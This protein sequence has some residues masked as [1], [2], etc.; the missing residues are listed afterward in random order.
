MIARRVNLLTRGDWGGL[1]SLLERDCHLANDEKE[2][3]R[4]G[5][6]RVREEVQLERNRKNALLLLSQG[7]ISKA[8]RTINS[9]GI[10]SMDDPHILQQMEQK[11]SER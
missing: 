7:K 6:E 1:L 10:G 3:R 5:Q 8:A 11:Y 2:R 9:H 4:R